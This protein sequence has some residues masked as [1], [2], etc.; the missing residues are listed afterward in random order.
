MLSWLPVI[1]INVVAASGVE[2]PAEAYAW[3]AVIVIPLTSATNPWVYNIQKW[4][5]KMQALKTLDESEGDTVGTL[6]QRE[7]RKFLRD[8]R[9][10]WSKTDVHEQ[11]VVVTGD[12]FRKWDTFAKREKLLVA[13]DITQALNIIHLSGWRH[14]DIDLGHVSL[15][16]SKVWF[17][18]AYLLTEGVMK[19]FN[20]PESEDNN[21][22]T[23]K[24]QGEPKTPHDHHAEA[25]TAEKQ[26]GDS[27][28]KPEASS[29]ESR[30]ERLGDEEKGGTI[31]CAEKL[32]TP[33]ASST[34]SRPERSGDEEKGGTIACADKL[35]TPERNQCDAMELNEGEVAD[36]EEGN[37]NLIERNDIFEDFFSRDISMLESLI[38]VMI[39][40]EDNIQHKQMQ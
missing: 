33:A 11:D 31:A 37:S 9:I 35:A 6:F 36:R 40:N 5:R 7:Q 20:E 32:P 39:P 25:D 19:Q 10:L 4:R 34:E 38:G 13:E 12:K 3:F 24:A 21:G 2:I 17:H 29:T 23:S 14:G 28:L 27:G 18:G 30:P 22:Q 26:S 15:T 1:F 16:T 8:S